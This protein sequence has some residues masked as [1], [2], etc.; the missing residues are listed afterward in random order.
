MIRL[1]VLYKTVED[2][3]G[4]VNTFFRNFMHY[5]EKDGRVKLEKNPERADI[6][7]SAC[8]RYAPE[9]MLKPWHLRNLGSGRNMWNPL[10]F[11]PSS[12]NM[13]KAVFRVD[14]LKGIYSGT[15]DNTSDNQLEQNLPFGKAIVFQS[16]F[17]M[18][19]FDEAGYVYPS[20]KTVIHNG[21]NSDIFYP[22]DTIKP[23]SDGKIKIVSSSW[24]TNSG[25]GFDVISAFSEVDGVDVF[26]I[27]RWPEGMPHGKVRLLGL[28]R[29][30]EIADVLREAHFFLFPSKFDACPNS[31]VEALACGIPVIYH[32]SGGSP[33]L[34]KESSFGFGFDEE[35]LECYN[36]EVVISKCISEYK[37]M[38]SELAMNLDLFTFGKC[39]TAYIDFIE[40]MI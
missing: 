1:G 32:R 9:K 40:R 17:S 3:Y 38:K 29:G 30:K 19:C 7:L 4:G 39:Y 22:S 13:K 33:E 16:H 36:I 21:A 15:K 25:K 18:Q 2:P 35:L 34:C 12:S 20:L 28:K 10:G 27:G 26:H 24:S 23:I 14:G 11:L 37:K 31:V 6:I 8:N 5:A